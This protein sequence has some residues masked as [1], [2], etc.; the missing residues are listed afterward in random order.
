MRLKKERLIGVERCLVLINLGLALDS[1]AA[2]LETQ[3]SDELW[4]FMIAGLILSIS[5]TALNTEKGFFFWNSDG[6]TCNPASGAR[7]KIL[8]SNGAAIITRLPLTAIPAASWTILI[9][10]P[11]HPI[12]DSVCNI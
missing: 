2:I 7:L 5:D 6:R 12:E 9:S 8:L 1:L 3:L 11:P 10:W 4:I